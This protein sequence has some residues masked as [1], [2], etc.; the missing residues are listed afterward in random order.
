VHL[1]GLDVEVEAVERV[2]LAERLVQAR[3]R[4]GRRHAWQAMPA[5]LSRWR[6]H[7]AERRAQGTAGR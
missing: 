3:D 4:D 1:T 5:M 2:G 7:R 6:E